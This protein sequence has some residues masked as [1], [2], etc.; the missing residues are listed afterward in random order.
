M[1]RSVLN[2]IAGDRPG[3]GDGCS[4][5]GWRY[6]DLTDE[7]TGHVTL[8]RK[9][10]LK[11]C[12]GRCYTMTQELPC[13]AHAP[14]YKVGMRGYSDFACKAPQKLEAADAR[15]GCQRSQRNWSVR[16]RVQALDG[17]R[18][19]RR[20]TITRCSRRPILRHDHPMLLNDVD[21]AAKQVLLCRKALC[22][23][24]GEAGKELCKAPCQNLITRNGAY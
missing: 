9:A 10:G 18:Y 1:G 14:L 13:Y 17:F 15:Q 2:K 24:S 22:P 19:A 12:L 20:P 7:C 11:S 3:S 6:A 4:I 23:R 21:Q 16:S 5:A 8:V